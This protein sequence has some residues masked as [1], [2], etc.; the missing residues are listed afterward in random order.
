MGERW[1]GHIRARFSQLITER[2]THISGMM[3]FV[4]IDPPTEFQILVPRNFDRV[5]FL[6]GTPD[7][8]TFEVERDGQIF[9]NPI[10]SNEIINGKNGNDIYTTQSG[11][12][13]FK[14]HIGL[15][16]IK[17]FTPEEYKL[18]KYCKGSQCSESLLKYEEPSLSD[19]S[20]IDI[21]VYQEQERD[22][23]LDGFQAPTA[24][25]YTYI[26]DFEPIE[27]EIIVGGI[28]YTIMIDENDIPM[29]TDN[30]QPAFGM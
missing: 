8:D 7:I 26:E 14:T 28:T 9:F 1:F 18:L 20:E 30:V 27:D 25:S 3:E 2:M 22:N 12:D 17:D 4:R 11:A 6:T 10:I 24:H 19:P 15:V 29:L 16:T 23:Y 13:T 5:D 21:L